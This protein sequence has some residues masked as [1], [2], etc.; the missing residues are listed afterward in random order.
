MFGLQV[1]PGLQDQGAQET[2][3]EKEKPK[4]VLW[5]FGTLVCDFTDI[6]DPG[7]RIAD[8]YH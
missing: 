1:Y 5:Y 7:P 6:E 2:F 8:Q 3:K 4:Y